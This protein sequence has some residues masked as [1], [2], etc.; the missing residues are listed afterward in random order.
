[1]EIRVVPDPILR[2]VAKPVEKL[3][4]EIINLISEM[5]R[6]CASHNGVGLA[7][8]QFGMGLRII[9]IDMTPELESCK[10]KTFINPVILEEFGST[11]STEGCLSIPDKK[12]RVPRAERIRF[13]ADGCKEMCFEGLVSYVVQHEI[14][15]CSGILISDVGT[16]IKEEE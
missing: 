6:F 13:I 8:P 12:Y 15:H 16:E 5:K 10:M 11:I 2:K 3:T 14:A 9:V 1:M 4:P 7:A